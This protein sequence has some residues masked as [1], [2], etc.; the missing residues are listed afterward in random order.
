M[1]TLISVSSSGKKIRYVYSLNEINNFNFD[2]LRTNKDSVKQDRV[3]TTVSSYCSKTHK[4]KLLD[5]GAIINYSYILGDME[6]YFDFQFSL[7]DCSK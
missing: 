5:D 4:R 1:T 6:P 2:L 7:K 3:K